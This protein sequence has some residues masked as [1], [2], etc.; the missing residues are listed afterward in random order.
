[1]PSE[2]HA[3][4]KSMGEVGVVLYD[5]EHKTPPD[6][7]SGFPY[8]AIPN[9]QGGRIDLTGVRLISEALIDEWNRRVVPKEDD[10]VFTRRG[11]VG[12]SAPIPKGMKCSIGQNLVILRSDGREVDQKYLRWALRGPAFEAEIQRMLNVGAVFDS[13][14]CADIPRMRIQ[15]PPLPEQ[16]AIAEVLGA[17]DDKI[18]SNRRVMDIVDGLLRAEVQQ[19][20]NSDPDAQTRAF[21]DLVE[22]VN[23]GVNPDSLGEAVPYIGLEHMP[24][25]SMIL[26]AWG[27]SEGLGSGKAKF[28]EKDILFGKLRPYFKKVGVA[29]VA[30]ICS[31]DVLVLRP[32][33]GTPL[34]VALPIAASDELI[35]YASAAS[36]GTRMPRV[37]WEYLSAFET[38]VPGPEMMRVLGQRLDP[39]L[40]IAVGLVDQ[41]RTLAATRDTLLPALLS[42]RIRVPAA[43]ELVEAS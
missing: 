13:L 39:L 37:S 11:R 22:R 24:R 32:S 10:I 16:R 35:D 9:I 29:P 21:G 33:D 23:V 36:T 38:E 28:G 18:E 34:S 41:N 17:L 15:V 7:G 30:G 31:T 20:T 8:L 26:D 25:G 2:A 43:A 5:C 1:M 27:D 42:G 6:E 19:A 4:L 12:D 40:E 3:P 14:N